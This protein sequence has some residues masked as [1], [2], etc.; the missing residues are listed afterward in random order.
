MHQKPLD[1]QHMAAPESIDQG[2]LARLLSQMVVR[3]LRAADVGFG[4]VAPKR[5]G[6]R[7]KSTLGYQSRRERRH[8]DEAF[9][10]R[11]KV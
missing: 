7:P 4:R 2:A 1:V 8:S 6:P 3:Q 9:G 10:S 11:A 5:A